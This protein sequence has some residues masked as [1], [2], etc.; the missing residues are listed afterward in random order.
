MVTFEPVNPHNAAYKT[1]VVRNF[2]S[3]T[4][5]AHVCVCVC[6]CVRVCVCVLS[7]CGY[8][9][10]TFSKPLRLYTFYII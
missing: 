1:V 4:L 7:H 2:R 8:T 3:D 9:L 6:V 10:F 5:G